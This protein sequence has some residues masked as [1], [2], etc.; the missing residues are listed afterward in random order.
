M[1]VMDPASI[2]FTLEIH[3]AEG[4][5]PL[6][7]ALYLF[8]HWDDKANAERTNYWLSVLLENHQLVLAAQSCLANRPE[9]HRE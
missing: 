3:P 9:E 6:R 4:R 1:E 2:S 7:D 8:E 5:L